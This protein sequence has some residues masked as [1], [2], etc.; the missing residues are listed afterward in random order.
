MRQR[1][2]AVQV[3]VMVQQHIGV[4]AVG[5]PAVSAG[6]FVL[7][8]VDINPAIVVAFLQHTQ[9]ILAERLQAFLRN[10]LGFLKRNIELV[11]VYQRSEQVVHM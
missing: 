2:H 6:P 4:C 10:L 11:F 7:I 3:V 1:E 5:S 9:I 8:F